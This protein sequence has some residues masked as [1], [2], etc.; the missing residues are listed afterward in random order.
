[1]S[2]YI[3]KL[4]L[5]IQ[6]DQEYHLWTYHSI[7]ISSF[8]IKI[9][10]LVIIFDYF[11]PR[12]SLDLYPDRIRDSSDLEREP[13]PAI[14]GEVVFLSTSIWRNDSSHRLIIVN[15]PA[16]KELNSALLPR[17]W[18]GNFDLHNDPVVFRDTFRQGVKADLIR[19]QSWPGEVRFSPEKIQA[20]VDSIEF[21]DL[22][23]YKA[24]VGETEFNA[25]TDRSSFQNWKR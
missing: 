16:S 18:V 5:N 21:L 4:V 25:E 11:G 24:R 10:Q 9:E 22:D 23:T 20:I 13:Y 14:F 12:G 17:D 19:M 1:M 15:Y 7:N 6:Y 2:Y 3:K 8:M